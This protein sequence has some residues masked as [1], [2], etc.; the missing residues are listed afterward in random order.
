MRAQYQLCSNNGVF[1]DSP[2]SAQDANAPLHVVEQ[3]R[4]LKAMQQEKPML[5]CARDGHDISYICK[6]C[7]KDPTVQKGVKACRSCDING[8]RPIPVSSSK[9]QALAKSAQPA[10]LS[11]D[12]RAAQW[13]QNKDQDTAKKNP[14]KRKI[15]QDSPVPDPRTAKSSYQAA[16]SNSTAKSSGK[17]PKV[18]PQQKPM[19]VPRIPSRV[20]EGGSSSRPI[21]IGSLD[22]GSSSIQNSAMA[23]A[24]SYPM[25][26]QT[27]TPFFRD[28]Q[29]YVT[30]LQGGVMRKHS[31][32]TN[33]VNIPWPHQMRAVD[34]F[35]QHQ[36]LPFFVVNHEMGTGKTATVAQMFAAYVAM[37]QKK[38]PLMSEYPSMLISVPTTTLK[39]WRDTIKNWLN[40]MDKHGSHDNYVLVTNSSKELHHLSRNRKIIVTTPGCLSQIHRKCYS[41]YKNVTMTST[42]KW[43]GGFLRSGGLDTDHG[44]VFDGYDPLLP[45]FD[46]TFDILAVDEVQRCKNPATATAHLH[47]MLSKL[48]KHRVLLSGTIVCNKPE[49]LSGIAY[50][51]NCPKKHPAYA[52]RQDFQDPTTFITNKTDY[53]KVNKDKIARFQTMWVDRVVVGQCN[54]F[55]PPLVQRAVNFQVNFT[56]EEAGRYTE[57]L[58]DLKKSFS[59]GPSSVAPV[60]A[61]NDSEPFLAVLTRMCFHIVHPL[62]TLASAAGFSFKDPKY[63]DYLF[64]RAMEN[65]S[66]SM[67]ALLVQLRKMKSGDRPHQRI[68]VASCYVIPLMLA[69]RWL[70]KCF[71]GEF[72]ETVMFTGEIRPDERE[73]N[74]QTFLNADKSIM[75]LNILAGGV[76]LH[77]V[78]GC[79]AMLFWAGLSYSPAGI[80]QCVARIQRFGQ[81]A[82]ITGRIEIVYLYPYGSRDYGVAKL[83]TDKRRVMRYAHDQDDSGFDNYLDNVWRKSIKILDDCL[84]TQTRYGDSPFLNFPPMPTEDVDKYGKTT[85]FCLMTGVE[86]CEL[87]NQFLRNTDDDKMRGV[88]EYFAKI[89]DLLGPEPTVF[90]RD[91]IHD[92]FG[93][94]RRS[95]RNSKD[96]AAVNAV[97]I[98]PMEN[99]SDDA[100]ND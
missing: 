88:R 25:E 53:K 5:L 63:R 29:H 85:Q 91:C 37:A 75:F 7:F 28:M 3:V 52:Q 89:V 15:V 92:F 45:P 59:S 98:D 86:T 83:H 56:Q 23:P 27:Y 18:V 38:N 19:P 21:A 22:S 35:M 30:T 17:S 44:V 77:L 81:L 74:K 65:P 33:D 20:A 82:P 39:Q 26:A 76:G 24:P 57:M 54:V 1:F 95:Q 16:A 87:E 9:S 12:E 66:S 51:G 99:L 42:G 67:L 68:V 71:P 62:I 72:G 10:T 13:Q 79:E 6:R 78:P 90:E 14:F 47:H 2:A 84:P 32:A 36:G 41:H 61:G 73:R 96:K 93:Q 69:K 31:H 58:C 34:K 70:D 11:L 97:E 60:A 43:I 48:S 64:D 80:D 55:L 8:L 49:D 46:S 94:Y 4:R 40:L 100:E 50:A